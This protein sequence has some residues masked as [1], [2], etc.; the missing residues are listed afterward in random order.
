MKTS[1]APGSLEAL[2]ISLTS[3]ESALAGTFVYA[4]SRSDGTLPSRYLKISLLPIS[5]TTVFLAASSGES[6]SVT[7]DSWKGSSAVSSTSL[8]AVLTR[9]RPRHKLGFFAAV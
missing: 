9:M 5:A 4:F 2:S 3:L 7:E 6:S 1:K 8:P